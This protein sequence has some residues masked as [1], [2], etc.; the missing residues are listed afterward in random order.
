MYMG[1]RGRPSVIFYSFDLF[2]VSRFRFGSLK[3]QQFPFSWKSQVQSVQEVSFTDC[4]IQSSPSLMPKPSRSNSQS[5][6]LLL[7][8]LE[9]V[10]TGTSWY[11]L[12]KLELVS[13]GTVHSTQNRLVLIMF[14]LFSHALT[15]ILPLVTKTLNLRK[16]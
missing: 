14:L 13:T 1:C 2:I 8:K 15:L 16:P 9:L 11:F 12:H 6:L 5:F 7:H 4:V 10:S 3:N